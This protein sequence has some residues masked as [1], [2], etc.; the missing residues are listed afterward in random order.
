MK[1]HL[2]LSVFCLFF[3][4]FGGVG[5]A[6]AADYLPGCEKPTSISDLDETFATI[7]KSKPKEIQLD[8]ENWTWTAYFNPNREVHGTA[9]CSATD[10]GT[11]SY[12]SS[13]SGQY[14]WC[15][16]E[17]YT[18]GTT[19]FNSNPTAWAYKQNFS[20][21]SKCNTECLKRC[22]EA[23]E[24]DRCGVGICYT[25]GGELP[26]WCDKEEFVSI[27]E[28]DYGFCDAELGTSETNGPNWEAHFTGG[29][30]LSGTSFCSA[31]DTGTYS[32]PSS[33]SGQYCWCGIESYNNGSTTF[34]SGLVAWQYAL[35]SNFTSQS[36]CQTGCSS[37]C[38]NFV[39]FDKCKTPI[40]DSKESTTYH[41]NYQCD[42]KGT[43]SFTDPNTY[44]SGD[45]VT[46]P[47]GTQC[48]TPTG[49]VFGDWFCDNNIGIV[50]GGGTFTMPAGDV[51][52]TAKWTPN[53]YTITLLNYNN[54]SIHSTIYE[55]YN[56]GWYSDSAATTAISSAP[57]PTRKGYKFRG[58]YTTTQSDLTASGG[59]GTRAITQ[60][61]GLPPNNTY[62]ANTD[63]Y[64]AWA[65]DCSA[66]TGCKC[67]LKIN[68]DGTATYTT[69]AQSGY[70]LTSG[71]GTYAPVCSAINYTVSFVPGNGGASGNMSS[72]T[73]K[74]IG[75]T[76]TL[77]A[78]G[79]TA[80]SG[81]VF[82]G[83]SC[84]NGIGNKAAN[85]Q[86]T[87]PAANVTCTAQW[88]TVNSISLTW[89]GGGTPSSCTYGSTFDVPT[90]TPR[91][92]YVF[93]GWRVNQAAGCSLSG[94]DPSIGTDWD[95]THTRW[96][97]I[98]SLGYTMADE[99]GTENSSDLNSGE[100]VVTFDYG[101]VKGMAICRSIDGSWATPGTP[102]DTDGKYCWCSATNY[103]PNGGNQ[104]NVASPSWVFY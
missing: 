4:L 19:T 50:S 57:V 1:K 5:V 69:T 23:I 49:Y 45:A 12:P 64:A 28:F 61:G 36:D 24:K 79:F 41:V 93:T 30:T 3:A 33:S 8:V 95:E 83:W 70:T 48:A 76:I 27:N 88:R 86:F 56:T 87:M 77:P 85:E 91:E 98:S 43:D 18:D 46:T 89:D 78:N 71:S 14:C 13:S 101:T 20:T 29:Q 99:F 94:L 62:T 47:N 6:H 84:D 55:K 51:T 66:G 68:S 63:L 53:I 102:S 37:E 7:C 17:S 35:D 103:T 60:T 44:S 32:Y 90:P 81:Y 59:S 39:G 40:C 16:I 21:L 2:F 73:G 92:G 15:G 100:W 25:P 80:P 42:Q 31:T 67:T 75:D 26:E 104:C 72:Q 38:I 82:N 65:Q 96:K 11:Y 52:C 54:T 34:S 22:K 74:H 9:F 58:F 97:P 10:A